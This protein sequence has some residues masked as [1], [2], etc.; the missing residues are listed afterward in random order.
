MK[1]SSGG[2]RS[3]SSRLSLEGFGF[4]L[5]LK[6]EELYQLGKQKKKVVVR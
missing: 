1:G 6:K 4:L 3:H 5:M 2:R